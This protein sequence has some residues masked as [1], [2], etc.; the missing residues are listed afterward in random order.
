MNKRTE[1]KL[2]SIEGMK[3]AMTEILAQAWERGRK[4]GRLE[5]QEEKMKRGCIMD[6]KKALELLKS[7]HRRDFI[8]SECQNDADECKSSCE[9]GQA[10][11]HAI[12]ALENQP[13][14]VDE[15]R[16][17]LV[18]KYSDGD[19]ATDVDNGITIALA[20]L[21]EMEEETT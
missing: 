4:Y 16:R 8:C 18:D 6:N 11:D 14:D 19:E 1:E 2:K 15:Y 12:K 17:R 21:D 7:T 5:A 13:F 9:Y 20:L 10:L 3:K